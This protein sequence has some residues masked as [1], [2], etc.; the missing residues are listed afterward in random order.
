MK[1]S[2]QPV[3]LN[4][5]EASAE[6]SISPATLYAYVS[7]GLIRSEAGDSP[8]S[9]RYRA[10]DVRA[11]KN[12]RAPA[13]E[14]NPMYGDADLPVLDSAI[15]EITRD[16]PLYRGTPAIALAERA[17]LEQAATLLWDAS[18][19]DP[20]APFNMPFVSD[21]M[22][23]VFRVARHAKAVDRTIAVLSLA[24]DADPHAFSR[25]P[26]GRAKAG[27]RILRLVI[28]AILSQS[29]TARPAH[30]EIADAWRS[31]HKDGADLIRRALVLLAD[32]EFNASTF[33]VRCAAS[34]GISLYDAVIAGLAALKGPRH[35]GAGLRSTHFVTSLEEGDARAIIRERV[36]LGEALPGFGHFLYGKGDPRA[37]F[38]IGALKKAKAPQKLVTDVPRWVEEATGEA[39]NV[40]YAMGILVRHL[41][42]PP[43]SELSLFAV[44]RTVGWVAH[45]VEQLQ[46]GGLIR[47]RA[48]YVGPSA[49]RRR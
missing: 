3:Y 26:E 19:S 33:T 1:N 11:L 46:K 8:R 14:R 17:S 49:A 15:T 39:P 20:F 34:T 41:G 24:S 31:D 9:R 36:A 23:D 45:A 30:I 21:S 12:R 47:P 4:A 42:L 6:L 5:G 7:R 38:L 37:A 44:A 35:G 27:A 32:H 16:G 40:D 28:A 10:E 25:T 2:D 29:P 43:G 13:S 22:A 18:S 48:R